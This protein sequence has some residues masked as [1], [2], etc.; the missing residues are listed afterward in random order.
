[1]K[2]TIVVMGILALT[3]M[4]CKKADVVSQDGTIKVDTVVV[5][6]TV[7]VELDTIVVG[8]N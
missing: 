4:S 8:R 5:A 3:V 7:D 2:K 1:M 6:D